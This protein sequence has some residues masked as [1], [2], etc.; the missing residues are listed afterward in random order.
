MRRNTDLCHRA[1]FTLVELLVVVSI[2]ALLIAILLPSL[3]KARESAKRVACNASLR[4]IAQAS[5]TY[6]SEDPKENA[7]PIGVGDATWPEMRF[8]Y[9]GF[10]GKSG[11]GTADYPG[12]LVSSDWSGANLMNSALRPLNHV[13]YPKGM[14]SPGRTGLAFR[15]DWS[16][17]FELSLDAYKCPGDRGFPGFHHNAWRR[18]GGSSYNFYGTSYAAN[19]SFVGIPGQSRVRTN[20]IYAR[21]LSR[22]PNPANTV[23]YWEN[24]ARYAL[25]APNP[26]EYDQ[27]GCGW[28]SDGG[29]Y[30]EAR[31]GGYIAHG[32]HAQDWHFNVAFGDGHSTWIKI[33]GH[34]RVAGIG[35]LLIQSTNGYC[36][37]G[38]WADSTCACIL[39]R[40][41]GWQVD[42]LPAVPLPSSK[43]VQ[44]F[45]GGG[46]APIGEDT[47]AGPD[48]DV[49]K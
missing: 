7:V 31:E 6:G 43:V 44:N 29:L 27:S 14:N 3:R 46:D 4:A 16:D 17:D 10:G 15:Q 22:V 39:V 34:G 21:P 37:G 41:L 40:G 25:W 45:P 48:Y 33:K 5:L 42:T 2:I 35:P 30:Y 32:H 9:Y 26:E 13:L 23:L 38:M 12:T 18:L 20:A 36:K 1:A 49:V 28:E 8:A 19:P 11:K 47:G 24:A